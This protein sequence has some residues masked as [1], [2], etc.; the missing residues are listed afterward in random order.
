MAASELN[1]VTGAFGYTGKHIARR[2]LA[3]GKRVIT[4]TGHP[5]RA[6]PFKGEVKAFLFNFDDS[7]LL[8]KS[9]EGV[10]TLYN[11]Y[12]VRFPH[13]DVSF[14]QA[15]ENTRRLIHAAVDA[16]VRRIVHL[17]I[18]NP[19]LDS[20]LPYFRGKAVVEQAVRESGLSY[21][22]IRPTVIFGEE[23]ILLNN[24]AFLL[25]RFPLFVIP[26]SGEYRLQPVYVE[27][28]AE[29][30][31][32]AGETQE[33]IVQDAAGPEVFTFNELVLMI[34]QKIGS[35]ARLVHLP[36]KT[37]LRL[38]RLAGLMVKDVLITEDEVRGLMAG[39]LVSTNP[40]TGRTRLSEYLA[41][42][43]REY[44]RR[45]ASELSRHYFVTHT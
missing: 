25:R 24:I 15:V 38:S 10:S 6:N 7:P 35:R 36:S 28:V 17:S 37:S 20:P 44:G 30:A 5:N 3:M 42:H 18:T 1:A 33:N 23:D 2:L 16:G 9:L 41:S 12:W 26:G 13:G 34:R 21:A 32:T 27:D 45:Y 31:V 43:W 8:S 22:I 11:T 4:L 29:I 14:G 19:S 39:L 40:P